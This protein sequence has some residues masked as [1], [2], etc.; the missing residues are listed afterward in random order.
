MPRKHPKSVP[1]R[2][3]R[4]VAYWE[5]GGQP[6]P[7]YGWPYNDPAGYATVGYG[8]LIALRGVTQADRDKWGQMTERRARIL[9]K[10]DLETSARAVRRLIRVPLDKSQ[11]SALISFTFNC[12]VGALEESTLRRLLNEGKYARVPLELMRW[13]KAG[14]VPMAGLTRRREAEGRMFGHKKPN[15]LFWR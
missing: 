1:N 13:N 10:K 9:L 6:L 8:H 11:F 5:L 3:V 12:G 7:N 2:A 14:G 15:P 4:F